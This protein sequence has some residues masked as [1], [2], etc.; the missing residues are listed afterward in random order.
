M[1]RQDHVFDPSII[2]AEEN[3]II[4]AQ[5]MLED[6]MAKKGVSRADLAKRCGISK[7]RI[8]QIFSS[9]ANPTVKT[10]AR[11]FHALGEKVTFSDSA[12]SSQKDKATGWEAAAHDE[13]RGDARRAS[14]TPSGFIAVAR[15]RAAGNDNKSRVVRLSVL[16]LE[17]A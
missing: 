12:Q 15:E 17:A 7:A 8:S 6:L 14:H 11:L 3:L 2:E 9:E 1:A 4:D 5:F 16:T 13:R 10:L